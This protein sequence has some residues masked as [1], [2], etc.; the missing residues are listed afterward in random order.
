LKSAALD[1]WE[2]VA[3][4]MPTGLTLDTMNFSDFNG[5][6]HLSLRGTA[7][8]LELLERA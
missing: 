5:A 1:C 7:N 6:R 2:A 8:I 3:E 4:T